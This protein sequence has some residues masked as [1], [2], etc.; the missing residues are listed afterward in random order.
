VTGQPARNFHSDQEFLVNAPPANALVAA[1]PV[2]QA[3]IY[4]IFVSFQLGS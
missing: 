2:R 1:P 3:N 4:L